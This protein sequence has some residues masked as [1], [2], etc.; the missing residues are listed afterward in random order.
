MPI[1]RRPVCERIGNSCLSPR[2]LG[3]RRSDRIGNFTRPHDYGHEND[4]LVIFH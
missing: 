1:L 2:G 3:L 4:I